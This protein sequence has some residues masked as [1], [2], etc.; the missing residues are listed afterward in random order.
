MSSVVRISDQ[1]QD[2]DQ[3]SVSIK[4][5]THKAV[6]LVIIDMTLAKL[7]CSLLLVVSYG[8][9]AAHA[10]DLSGFFKGVNGAFVVY[11]IKNDRY[12]RYN[13]RRCRQRFSPK[14]T[15]KI[16]NSLIGLETGV[17]RAIRRIDPND[18]E[19][20]QVL[21]D[22]LQHREIYIQRDALSALAVLAKNA[23]PA[24]PAIKSYLQNHPAEDERE[25]ASYALKRWRVMTKPETKHDRRLQPWASS[26]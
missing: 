12:V 4:R 7:A 14:L 5:I 18:A 9:V 23:R 21:I 8:V 6:L 17:I 24:I 13:Q 22:L 19:S 1:A 20:L 15:F 16:P 3:Y 2:N 10:Q 25:Y 26:G 11:D